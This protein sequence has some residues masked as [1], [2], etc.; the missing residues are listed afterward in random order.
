MTIN[1]T[2]QTESQIFLEWIKT[3]RLSDNSNSYFW[4]MEDLKKEKKPSDCHVLSL[5]LF[6]W[7][8]YI[9]KVAILKVQKSALMLENW[10]SIILENCN[11]INNS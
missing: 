3:F 8:G 10:M 7:R 1:W 6:F 2:D 4:S 11:G 5:F 9:K